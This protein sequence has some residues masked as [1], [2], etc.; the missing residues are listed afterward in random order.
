[1]ARSTKANKARQLNAAYAL[2]QR[3]IPLPDAM[4]RLSRGFDLSERQAYRYLKEAAQLH[5]PVEV[6]EVTVS[7]TLKLPVG[8]ALFCGLMREEVV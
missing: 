7:I 4:Q 2:L 8:T 3:N 6:G 1:M 5:R